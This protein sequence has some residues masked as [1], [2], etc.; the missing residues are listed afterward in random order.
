MLVE[1]ETFLG[2]ESTYSDDNIRAKEEFIARN[3][4]FGINRQVFLLSLCASFNSAI[5]GFNLGVFGGVI[6]I[7]Q[8]DMNL[9]TIQAEILIGM[10][11]FV[12]IFGSSAILLK[13]VE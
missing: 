5:I 9:T 8:D 7:V 6:F 3:E 4:L 12:A 2:E 10:L 11:N 13:T 1:S